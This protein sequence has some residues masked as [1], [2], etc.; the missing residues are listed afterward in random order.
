MD[1][2]VI[3]NGNF[4][5]LIIKKMIDKNEIIRYFPNSRIID[6]L[7]DRILNGIYEYI[8]FENY[9]LLVIKTNNKI[10]IL[11]ISDKLTY[12]LVDELT[13]VY[14]FTFGNDYNR[15]VSFID[16]VKERINEYYPIIDLSCIFDSMRLYD[17]NLSHLVIEDEEIFFSLRNF[18]DL[19]NYNNIF[20]IVRKDTL[21]IVGN[22]DFCLY[23]NDENVPYHGNVSYEIYEKHQ[24]KGYATRALKL[25][26]EF[27]KRLDIDYSKN[28][29]ISML[30]ENEYSRKV[31]INNGGILYKDIDIPEN[32]KL[33]FLGKVN[34][35]LIYKISDF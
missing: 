2:K 34:H 16:E 21:E 18:R 7:D 19:Y 9:E 13:H 27:I 25:L 17:K 15:L 31:A 26:K 23:K 4:I 28:L 29:Y 1:I 35:V 10:V 30:K 6:L 20:L 33:H 12:L 5:R 22:I 8:H 24:N 11:S 14:N 3:K 32:D